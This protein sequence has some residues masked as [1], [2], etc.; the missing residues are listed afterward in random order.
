MQRFIGFM[1]FVLFGLSVL[2]QPLDSGSFQ[3][4]VIGGGKHAGKM[5]HFNPEKR[6]KVTTTTG[7][8]IYTRQYAIL[9]D[10]ILTEKHGIIYFQDIVRIKG[11][12]MDN[13]DR[14]IGGALLIPAGMALSV[15]LAVVGALMFGPFGTLMICS[16][17]IAMIY[18]GIKMVG[19]RN[20]TLNKGWE[21]H[22]IYAGE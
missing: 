22:T 15:P 14:V 3:L 21:V 12:V 7:N 11:R 5:M 1:F 20:F 10:Q 16:P 17:A 9:A 18:G 6:L 19:H 2:A 8:V 4:I 13:L